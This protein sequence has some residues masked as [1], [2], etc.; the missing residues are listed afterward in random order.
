MK[1]LLTLPTLLAG[2]LLT[3]AVEAAAGP[4]ILVSTLG[5]G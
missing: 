4:D 3:D 2:N 1:M 5:P